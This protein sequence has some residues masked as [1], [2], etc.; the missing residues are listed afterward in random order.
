M[1]KNIHVTVGFVDVVIV[2]FLQVFSLF[3]HPLQLMVRPAWQTAEAD[4]NI[5]GDVLF[6]C[7]YSLIDQRATDRRQI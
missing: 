6:K 2:L 7:N 3:N 5:L 1:V 4:S